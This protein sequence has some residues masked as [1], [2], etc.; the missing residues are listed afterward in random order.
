MGPPAK[1]TKR[2]VTSGATKISD[3][4]RLA[5]PGGGQRVRYRSGV[6]RCCV[7]SGWCCCEHPLHDAGADA[8]GATDLE[9]AHVALREARGCVLP[10][11]ASPDGGPSL[12]PFALA[13]A[14]PALTRSRMM[15]RSNS[16]NT[17]SIWNIALPAVVDG[18]ETLL[19]QEQIDALVVQ[20]LQDAEQIG[21]RPAEAIH[22]PSGDHI[23]LLGVDGLQHCI[24]AQDA[25]RALCCR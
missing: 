23:E 5:T 12:V 14:S 25:C 4:A 21:E 24:E 19:M 8:D 7:A 2:V 9:H 13:R 3:I 11:S 22:R 6:D 17:P 10:P 16:A 18:V 15:P 20:V 1:K